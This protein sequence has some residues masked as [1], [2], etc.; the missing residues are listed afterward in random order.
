MRSLSKHEEKI[1]E[2]LAQI[3]IPLDPQKDSR[4]FSLFIQSIKSH[5]KYM[6]IEVIILYK[7]CLWFVELAAFFYYGS[8]KLMT[9]MDVP[10][11]TDYTN[12]SFF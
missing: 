6:R 5:T 7:L 4:D 11:R 10:L 9:Q 1:I 2:S 8:L 3:I 12:I